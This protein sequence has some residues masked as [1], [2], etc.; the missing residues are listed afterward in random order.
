MNEAVDKGEDAADKRENTE[1]GV[2]LVLMLTCLG[3]KK[4]I[5]VF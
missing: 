5:S 2:S 3:F 4:N 1:I